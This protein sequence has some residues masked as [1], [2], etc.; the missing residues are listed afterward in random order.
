[1]HYIEI[2]N[3]STVNILYKNRL[4]TFYSI[5]VMLDTD[6]YFVI[7]SP[8]IYL[9]STISGDFLGNSEHGHELRLIYTQTIKHRCFEIFISFFKELP[10]SEK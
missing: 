4:S 9:E 5:C 2:F 10:G 7:L 3:I 8:V 6:L 1:M